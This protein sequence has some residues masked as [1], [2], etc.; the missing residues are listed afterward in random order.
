[1]AIK[2]CDDII[3]EAAAAAAVDEETGA[4]Y[5]YSHVTG[6]SVWDAEE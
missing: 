6:E 3:D 4:S 1:M 2:K 5:W